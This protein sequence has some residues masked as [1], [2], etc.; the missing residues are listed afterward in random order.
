MLGSEQHT[1]TY[2]LMFGQ[3]LNTPL[4]GLFP[5]FRYHTRVLYR[6]QEQPRT[7]WAGEG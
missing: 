1:F 6:S 7:L 4:K 2:E 3:K 5:H